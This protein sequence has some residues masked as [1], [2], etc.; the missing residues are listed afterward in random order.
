MAGLREW[1]CVGAPRFQRE[2]GIEKLHQVPGSSQAR[3]Y[4]VGMHPLV[5]A[6]GDAPSSPNDLEF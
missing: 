2:S 6:G 5:V 3:L 4:S 1:W